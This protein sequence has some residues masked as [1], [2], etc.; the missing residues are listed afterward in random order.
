MWDTISSQQAASLVTLNAGSGAQACA[1]LLV[2]TA[3]KKGSLDN[4]TA[5]VIDLRRVWSRGS[6]GEFGSSNT[7]TQQR[8]SRRGSGDLGAQTATRTLSSSFSFQRRRRS[9][10][11]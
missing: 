10:N 2:S 9:L 7:A 11:M 6:L 5:M 4:A 3:L 1:D 8:S